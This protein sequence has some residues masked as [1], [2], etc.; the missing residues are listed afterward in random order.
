MKRNILTVLLCLF[1][2]ALLTAANYG[3]DHFAMGEYTLAKKWFEQNQ[4]QN[5]AE[6]S[7]YLGEIAFKEGN[8]D[9][10]RTLFEKGLAANP[11][12]ALNL[13]GKGKT[14]LKSSKKE[15]EAQFAAALKINKKDM[16]V[17]LA[18]VDAYKD[19][20]MAEEAEKKLTA[21]RKAGKNSPLLYIYDGNQIMAGTSET[22]VSDAA[23]TYSQAMYFDP[24][25]AVAQMKYAQVY[26]LTDSYDRSIDTEKKVLEAHPDYTIAIRDLAA[27]Y[28][29]KGVYKLAIENYKKYF[30]FGNFSVLDIRRF[31]QSYFFNDQFKEAMTLIEQGLAIEPDHFVLNRLR[32]YSAAK[33]KDSLGLDYANKFFSLR[34]GNSEES[35]FIYRDYLSYAIIL[36]N[37][38]R[39]EEALAQFDKV[40]NSEERFDKGE[41][42]ESQ[43]ECYTK[44]NQHAKAGDAYQN[45][46]TTFTTSTPVSIYLKQGQAY[47]KAALEARKDTTD[48]GKVL[49]VDYATKAD[50]AFAKTVELAPDSYV[51]YMWRGNNNV[52]LDP[53]STK[54]LAKPY[55]EGAIAAITKIQ[56]EG[57]PLTASH[58]SQLKT[59]YLY[60]AVFYYK[61]EDKTNSLL[62]AGKVQELD[63]AEKITKQIIEEYKIQEAAAAN[64]TPAKK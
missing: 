48:A 3:V 55:F 4:A 42:Y 32:M 31:A 36:A 13:V 38:G 62:Y 51:G 23:S 21:A 53:E 54:G 9:A 46:V 5:P 28:T 63:S 15:A 2:T 30:E 37:A 58:K 27:G 33:L 17:L 29:N 6:A 12:Y 20:G 61:A 44:M 57:Q 14:L 26:L 41:L 35:K 52:L 56:E 47:Y 25:N 1:A 16:V 64:P 50:S 39:Y 7:Y 45:Y 49:L 60:L 10:A 43:A 59:S 34:S 19:N 11:A 22:K 24:E 40:V 18:I 8:V